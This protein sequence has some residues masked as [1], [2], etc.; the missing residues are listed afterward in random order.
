MIDNEFAN[1]ILYQ[2]IK[3]N[4]KEISINMF[5]ASTLGVLLKKLNYENLNSFITLIKDD[6]NDICLTE[7][8]SHVIQS[9]I[10]NILE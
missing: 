3:N 2:G 1:N 7:P 10:Q 5:G 4:L 6:I 9:L 8:G